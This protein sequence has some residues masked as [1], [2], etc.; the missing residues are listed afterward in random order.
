MALCT[1]HLPITD[2]LWCCPTFTEGSALFLLPSPVDTTTFHTVNFHSFKI[3]IHI[4]LL[5]GMVV[6][7]CNSS[8]P[9]IPAHH[10]WRQEDLEFKTS[11]GYIV[12]LCLKT[13]K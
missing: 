5:S 1:P 13:N 11:L 8:T 12:K 7:T 9:E 4:L 3:T 2:P 6:L 10:Q